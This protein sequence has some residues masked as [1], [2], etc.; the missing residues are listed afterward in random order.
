M[1]P[2]IVRPPIPSRPKILERSRK[3]L[4]HPPKKK[5]KLKGV[6]VTVCIAAVATEANGFRDWIVGLQT[7]C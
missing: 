7:Q 1:R 3:G 6:D 5:L 2:T 4:Y